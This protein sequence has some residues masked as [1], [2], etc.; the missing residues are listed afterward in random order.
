MLQALRKINLRTIPHLVH[1]LF[2]NVICTLQRNIARVL[3]TSRI[4]QV[5]KV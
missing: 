5:V 3:M 2:A 1:L 4:V